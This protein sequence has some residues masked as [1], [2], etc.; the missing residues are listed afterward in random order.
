[1]KKIIVALFILVNYAALAQVKIGPTVGLDLTN[2]RGNT[3]NTNARFAFNFG[4]SGLINAADNIDIQIQLLAMG[5]GYEYKDAYGYKNILKPVYLELP[6]V[7]RFKFTTS[8]NS[9][10]FIGAGGY[11]AFGVAG[12]FTYYQNGYKESNKIK[13]GNSGSDNLKS[14]DFGMTFQ[15]GADF[16]KNFEGYFFYDLGLSNIIPNATTKTY[17][18][19]FGF[20]LAWYFDLGKKQ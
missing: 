7:A 20:N 15:I 8:D 16:H 3:K 19:V 9:E 2:V 13:Y 17:N 1:M 18:S 6:I 10:L 11:A 5:K 4:A 14:T 12:K